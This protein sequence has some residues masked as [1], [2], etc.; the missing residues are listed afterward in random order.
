MLK[1]K[2]V[3]SLLL[4]AS[5]LITAPLSVVI[6]RPLPALAGKCK[7]W[8]VFCNE[9]IVCPST[10]YGC[11]GFKPYESFP[12]DSWPAFPSPKVSTNFSSEQKVK[13]WRSLRKAQEVV[14][15]S[16]VSD[17]VQKYV[18]L[19]TGEYL[20]GGTKPGLSMR[21]YIA[22]LPS[23]QR[24][25]VYIDPYTSNDNTQLGKAG[26]GIVGG[27]SNSNADFRIS[28]NS[29]KLASITE[30][31]LAG[32]IV[33][34]LLHNWGYQHLKYDMTKNDEDRRANFVYVAGWC[35]ASSG[36]PY[37]Q[38]LTGDNSGYRE[39]HID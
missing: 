34:E 28:L 7:W 5:L 22:H 16:E 37:S 20:P 27:P 38:N 12:D 24:K 2:N 31:D 36:A 29:A 11:P 3:Q 17:C 13:I 19:Q 23:Q 33:H 9:P 35:V 39:F 14:Q 21:L 10:V 32:V 26:V 4:C 6:T 1:F 25:S 15:K 18:N 8:Q 30:N